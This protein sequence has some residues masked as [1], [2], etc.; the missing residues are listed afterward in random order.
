MVQGLTGH[1][2]VK[3][4]ESHAHVMKTDIDAAKRPLDTLP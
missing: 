1:A 2:D 4:T 3:T